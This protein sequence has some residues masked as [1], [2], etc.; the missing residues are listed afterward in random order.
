MQGPMSDTNGGNQS[1]SKSPSHEG[2]KDVSLGN[3][4]SRPVVIPE[5]ER[6]K[7]HRFWDSQPVPKITDSP[8]IEPGPVEVKVVEQISTTPYNLPKGFKWKTIDVRKDEELRTLV[9]LLSDNYVEDDDACFRFDYSPDCLRWALTPPEYTQDWH[10]GVF[11]S[12][13]LVAFISAVPASI[14]VYETTLKVAEVNFLCVHK[15]LRHKRLAPVLIKEITR[16]INRTGIWQALYTAGVYLPR[17]IGESQYWHRPLN[18]AKLVDVG[19]SVLPPKQTMQIAERLTALPANHK[20]SGI[21]VTTTKDCDKIYELFQ[22]EFE[23]NPK[24]LRPAFSK[25][26]IAH[27]LMP[28]KD[29]LYSYVREVDGVIT[30]FFSFYSLPS[31]VI[32]HNTRYQRIEVAYCYYVIANTVTREA[33]L[34]EA[35]IEAKNCGFDV[36]NALDLGGNAETFG[37]LRFGQGDGLL[38]YYLYNWKCSQMPASEI[39]VVLL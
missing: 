37:N 6:G 23:K 10:L 24:A 19:F 4:V 21:R 39:A 9:D 28:K 18:I 33:L 31:R 32:K 11:T 17:P 29:V 34:Y 7:V 27:W 8:V 38:R 25:D 35:L 26:D 16:R 30:D 15:A 12:D 20:L 1:P 36:F 5:S 14:T 22:A 3:R 13:K 2:N